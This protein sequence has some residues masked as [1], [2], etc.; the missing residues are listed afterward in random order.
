MPSPV[1]VITDLESI[2]PKKRNEQKMCIQKFIN[3][4]LP[5][6]KVMTLDKNADGVNLLRRIGNQKKKSVLYRDRRP[7]LLG[8]EVVYVPDAEGKKSKKFC[9]IILSPKYS[10]SGS[11]GTLKITGYLRG[12]TLSVNQ[13]IHISG[14]GDFQMSQID[15]PPDPNKINKVKKNEMEVNEELCIKVL[16]KAD[17]AKLES[18]ESEN[19]PDPMDAEQTWPTNEE[20]EMAEKEQKVCENTF[21]IYFVVI[22]LQQKG[23]IIFFC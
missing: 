14:L 13:L 23:E 7:H 12:T 22:V 5:D 19:I 16:E 6:E 10:Y 1:V 9:I 11:L 15:A 8:E 17:P 20:I 3:K 21:V 4:W 18:L 2:A